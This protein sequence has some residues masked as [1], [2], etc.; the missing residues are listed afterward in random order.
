MDH[1]ILKLRND[2]FGAFSADLLAGC[3]GFGTAAEF[4][5]ACRREP[6]LMFQQAETAEYLFGEDGPEDK[7]VKALQ[8]RLA[9]AGHTA[10]AGFPVTPVSVADRE[11]EKLARAGQGVVLAQASRIESFR[12]SMT[13]AALGLATAVALAVGGIGTPQ[14]HAADFDRIAKDF[15]GGAA[16]AALGGQFG[17][18]R[19]KTVMQVVGAAAGVAVAESMQRQ[20]QQPPGYGGPGYSGGGYNS[21]S[22]GGPSAGGNVPLAFDARE[23]LGQMERSAL[24]ARDGYARSLAA[25]Q[26]AEDARVLSPNDKN[27]YQASAAANS[28]SQ[29]QGQLYNQARSEFVNAYEHLA[30]RGYDVHEFSY[31]YSMTQQN[32][33]SRDVNYRDMRGTAM[34]PPAARSQNVGY[35]GPSFY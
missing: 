33:S 19:G 2:R 15:I 4:L 31:S 32:V 18:G 9:A 12:R 28:T 20:Q 21:P 35:S 29:A 14:A 27:V 1:V 11:F 16:G 10:I 25:V 22:Y 6:D 30:R 8:E 26:Q 7:A 13:T 17:K 23:K 34:P 3:A 5:D 24:M